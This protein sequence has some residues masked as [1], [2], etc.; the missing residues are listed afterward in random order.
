MDVGAWLHGL[1]LGQYETMFRESEIDAEVLPDLTEGDLNQLGVPLGHRKRLL[2]AIAALGTVGATA[3]PSSPAPASSPAA[4]ERRPITVMFCDL[5]GSTRLAAKLDAE[6]WRNLV[7]AYLDEA[8]AAVTDLGGHVLKKLG[9]GLM[10]L[11]GYPH[12]Q[13]NDA[14]RAVRAALAI[15]RAL[16]EINARN[17]RRGAPE[18]SARIGL[19]SGQVVVD[20]TG[21]V[22]GDAPNI[23]ARVQG[24]A[25]PGSILITAA[26]QRQTAGLFV[27]EDRGQHELKGVS[28]PMTLY[29]VVRASG[30]GRRSGVRA[31]T[32]LVGREEE[33]DL[34][35]RRWE[36]A[37]NG[38]G[39]LALIV[40]E[41]GLGK[42]RLMEEFHGRLGETP[43]SWVEWSS[44]QLLQNTPLH[45]IAEWG[46]Q[47]FGADLPAEQRLTDLEH[48]LRLVGLDP[49]EY[50]PLLAPL[51]DVL[52]PEDRVAKL[53]PEELR[54]RQLAAMTAWISAAARTQAIVLAFEDLH[55]ADPTSLDLMRALAERGAQAPLLIIATARP[56]FRPPWS[57]RSHHSVIS[58][59]PLDSVQI[60]KMVAELSAHHALP[61]DI[62]EGVSERTGGVPLFVEEV[63]RLLLE[64]G[65][66]GGAQAIPPTLQQ[67]LAARLDRLG[68]ARETAQIGAVLGRGFSYALLQSVAGLDEGALRSALERLAEADVLFVEGDGPQANYRF[69]H[70]LIQDAAY[71]SLLKSRRQALHAQAAEILRDSASPE[72]EAIA[73]HFTQAGLDDL[74]IEWWGKAG[75][76]ALRRSAFQEAI[77]HLGK[78]IAMADKGG[79]DAAGAAPIGHRL[80]LQT[81]YARAI[82]W[83]R[84]YAADETKAAVARVQE[85]VTGKDDI[86]E[87]LNAYYVQIATK[88]VNGEVNQALTAALTFLR[89]SIA[90]GELPD[91]VAAHRLSGLVYL[92]AGA[93]PDARMHLE[94]AIKSY[95]PDWNSATKCRHAV[96]SGITATAY[97]AHVCWQFGE[98]ARARE[99][100]DQA[101]AR[102]D[103]LGHIPTLAN[104]RF[105]KTML[106]MFR[107]EGESTLRDADALLEIARSNGLALYLMEG[108]IYR[109]W[110]RGRLGDR[111]AARADMRD[112]L[113][114]RTEAGVRA[115]PHLLGK[116]AELDAECQSADEATA[117]I[118]E[119]LELADE[120]GEH[121]TDAFLH[122]IRGDILLKADPE[123]RARAEDA[124]LSAIA[125]G[126]KRGARSFGLQAALKLAKLYQSTTRPVDAHAILVPALEGFSPTPEMPEIG[127]AHALVATLEEMDEVKSE[128]ARRRRITQLHAA[129]GNAMILAHGYGARE[130]AAAFERAR[131]TATAQDG[132]ERLLAQYG[133]WAGSFVRGELGAMRELS[134][135]ML[136]DCERRPQSG[137]ASIAHRMRGVTHWCAGEFVAAR[138]HLEKAIA[139]FDPERDGDLAFRFGQDPGIVA[140]AYLAEVLW[141]LGEVALADQRMTETTARAVKS[142]HAATSAYGFLMATRFE[143]IRRNPDR[144]ATFARSLIKIANEHQLPFWMAISAWFDG[145]LEW[146]SGDR[147]P[148]LA[149]MRNSLARQAEQGSVTTFFETLLAEAEA[150]AGESDVAFCTINH[151]L[152]ASERTGLHWY[153]AETHRIRGEILLRGNSADTL[154]A[155]EAFQRAIAVAGEQGARSFQLR[156]AL[157]L[158]KLYQATERP[159]DAHA[160]LAPALEG[161]APT[162]EMPE[163]AEAQSLLAALAGTEEVKAEAVRRQRLTQLHVSYGNALIAARGYGAP[164]TTEAFARARES[165]VG[166]KTAPGRLSADYG[167]WVGSF[168]RGELQSMRA[169]SADF[170]ND[171][172]AR[173]DSPEAGVAHRVAG[174]TCWFAGEYCDANDHLERALALFQPGRDDDMAFR[175][176]QDLGVSAMAYLALVLWPLGE[177]ERAASFISRMLARMASLTHG[178]TIA[179]G[180]M[181]AAQFALMHGG[182]MAGKANSLE[183]ARIASAHDLAQFRAFGM[184]FDGWARVESD[185]LGGLDGMRGGVDSLRAQDIR[186]FDGLVKIALAKTEAEAG[187]PGRAAAILNE[188]LATADRLGHR[189]FEAELHRARGEILLSREP[190]NPAPAEDAFVTAIAVAKRQ[191][192]RSFELR[193]ALVLAKLY[194]SIARPAD[195]HAVLAPALTGFAPTCEFPEIKEALEMIAAIEAGSHL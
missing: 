80:K 106:E 46:R 54:R 25:E 45:P 117:Q 192:A 178:N 187:D 95:D 193:A 157:S 195:A 128:V 165:A 123:N 151:A 21:E 14:E 164:E 159:T 92:H 188:A 7:S 163:I 107:D 133:L 179:L 16:V 42:S 79:G 153:D 108:E 32:P 175:F 31:L 116:L 60:A 35:G 44:S 100:I 112:A 91:I 69:K 180:H 68:V 47:R 38:E 37:R 83:S 24:A 85:L 149:A 158:A 50:A 181:F 2:K 120:T 8:S 84:G 176:G 130:T 111:E 52:L 146:R 87:R 28:A 88:L 17:A 103:D 148:G 98:L 118:H 102:A 67:S 57:V 186:I 6:D 12:A 53:A 105:F 145:W 166:D 119:G 143:L 99:L 182:P 23:A 41:P 15:Q 26:V 40:G 65:E 140:T 132:F 101:T 177:I 122:R 136:R 139:I 5:V 167:L 147:K 61:R 34:L 134:A 154:T 121:W 13:E 29:R 190:A 78:A 81:N 94:E 161:L 70:A 72:P 171:V 185:L 59:S 124:Y 86:A 169:H 64:R 109:A 62:V 4:A 174:A 93:L 55:W 82:A 56:E 90:E 36:R 1:G 110:A 77:A 75:D 43:Y 73:H 10:A 170:L 19:D 58:L 152:A 189:T 194:Q 51:V 155:E 66:Q 137:E 156:A 11:F 172:Q 114:K 33:L 142:G 113:A 97:L 96:D 20:A 9:D 173:P 150:E 115:G 168:T 63:T 22:F 131:D 183:L 127:E 30:G 18:L 104:M 49:T 129:Y 162:P 191:G 27:A 71:D 144:A 3:K 39:Q 126:R 76:Q 125:I 74:A 135:A 141:L 48:T 184:F 160:V 89:E 138:G